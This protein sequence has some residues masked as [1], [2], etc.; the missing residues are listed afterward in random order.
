VP[1]LVDLVTLNGFD[2]T[3][4]FL[5]QAAV[6]AQSNVIHGI[7]RAANLHPGFQ[8]QRFDCA[9]SASAN[10]LIG[11]YDV[12]T[13]IKDL[14]EGNP[15]ANPDIV[16]Y[17]SIAC[18][19]NL[20]RALN[21]NEQYLSEKELNGGRR[22]LMW[23]EWK[24]ESNSDLPDSGSITTGSPWSIAFVDHNALRFIAQKGAYFDLTEFDKPTGYDVQV[25]F[26]HLMG[27]HA[28]FYFG[29]SGVVYDAEV[30]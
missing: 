13:R 3:T 7:P 6:G 15:N 26:M 20:K 9:G 2:N 22:V 21:T 4:G 18:Q 28:G 27:Q 29:S 30:W 16:G 19:N 8:N 5:E 25:A 10:L 12:A 24:L 11:A 1:A 23:G 14:A 17:I